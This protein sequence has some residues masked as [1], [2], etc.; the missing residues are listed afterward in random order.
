MENNMFVVTPMETEVALS[1]GETF[2]GTVTVANPSAATSDFSFVVNVSPYYVAGESY[3]IDLTNSSD[4]SQI[5]N[6]ITIDE[7]RGTL[8]PNE[9]K[10]I[11]FTINVP[12]D[13]P[14]GAQYAAI[15]V[16]QDKAATG[17]VGANIENVFEITHVIYANIAGE[18]VNHQAEIL[19]N[20]I[21]GF[22]V[23]TPV[24]VSALVNNEGDV[25]ERAITEIAVKNAITGEQILPTA[26]NH[27][28]QSEL[29]LP[30]T[31]RKLER[32]IGDLPAVGVVNITQTVY[33]NGKVSTE[34]RN[35]IIFPIWLMLIILIFIAGITFLIIRKIRRV[36]NKGLD[37]H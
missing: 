17:S 24:T 20:S 8:K 32:Q 1:S 7:T 11:S 21:P 14:A 26:E 36:K 6:W 12:I 33:Y 23:T 30:D 9:S 10:K 18:A 22:T 15:S 2:T 37:L 35:L 27:G 29:I 13:A 4:R 31:T 5:V 3:N 34:T 19:E 16:T 25:H 28:Q